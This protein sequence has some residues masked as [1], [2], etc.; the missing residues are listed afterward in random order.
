MPPDSSLPLPSNEA[1]THLELTRPDDWHL[2][3]RDAEMLG[4]VVPYTARVFGRAVVMPNLSPPV[5]TTTRARTQFGME[6]L[7]DLT[8]EFVGR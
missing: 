7:R 6:G 8:K 2:H 5:A 1:P 3:L 4:R